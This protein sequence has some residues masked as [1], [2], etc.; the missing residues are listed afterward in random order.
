M[1][2]LK[3]SIV[4]F[5][6]IR[7]GRTYWYFICDQSDEDATLSLDEVARRTRDWPAAFKAA[8]ARTECAYP[9]AIHARGRPSRLGRGQVICIGDAAHGMEPT[10]GQGACQGLEP[11]KLVARADEVI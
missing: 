2:R 8:V 11:D 3:E 9:V 6:G 1:R 5:S 4:T 7:R 10:L